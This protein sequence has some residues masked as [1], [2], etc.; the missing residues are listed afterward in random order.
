M[1]QDDFDIS[2][3]DP[4]VRMLVA[5]LRQHGFDTTDSGDGSKDGLNVPHV[6]MVCHAQL[7]AFEADRL[8]RVL[9]LH[10]V[11][12]HPISE[13]TTHGCIQATYDPADVDSTATISLLGVNDSMLR[14]TSGAA[15][16]SF[17]G[18]V[19]N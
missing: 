2:K 8:H 6:H 5:L 19:P 9:S 10:G 12:L 18:L 17:R 3:I 7:L 13:D 16:R 1:E 15:D 11:T 14:P 4:G